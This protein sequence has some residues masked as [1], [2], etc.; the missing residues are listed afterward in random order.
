VA[1]PNVA[2]PKAV[3]ETPEVEPKEPK[4]VEETPTT[5][6]LELEPKVLGPLTTTLAR[7]RAHGAETH[8]PDR[9]RRLKQA[10]GPA[11]GDGDPISLFDIVRHSGCHDALWAMRA[12]G[13]SQEALALASLLRHMEGLDQTVETILGDADLDDLETSRPPKAA[14]LAEVDGA[15]A[16]ITDDVYDDGIAAAH[17]EPDAGDLIIVKLR[18]AAAMGWDPRKDK[19]VFLACL[20]GP[21]GKVGKTASGEDD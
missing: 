15:L 8:Y 21:E 5:S 6:E 18:L 11:H 16:D 20:T 2:E 4:A 14:L 19:E 12:M 17:N 10:L 9:Y 13:R 3:E 7:L 1:E